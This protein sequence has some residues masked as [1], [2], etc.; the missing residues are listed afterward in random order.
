MLSLVTVPATVALLFLGGVDAFWRMNCGIIHT[1]RVDP[2]V[3]P[4]AVAAHAHTIVGGS[5]IGVNATFNTLLNSECTSCEIAA[6]KSAYWTP[7]LYYQYPN[8]TFLEVP[9]SGSVVYYLARG[10]NADKIIP[11]PK[12]FMILTG[13]KGARSYDNETMTWGN[14]T[15]P[16]R[17]IADRISFVCLPDGPPLPEGRHMFNTTCANGMR[18]QI[19]FQSCWNGKELYKADN[20]HVAYLN[21]IDN[22]I[23]PPDHPIQLPT[24][25]IETLWAVAQVSGQTPQGRFVFSQGDPTGYGFHADFQNGWDSSVLAQAVRDC[26]VPDNFGQISYCPALQASQTNGYPFNCPERPSQI[27]EPVHG[28]LDHLP[29]CV[30]VTEGP[31][32]APASSMNCPASVPKPKIFSTKDSTPR[33]TA[34]PLPG[35]NFG[36]PQQKYLGCYNDSANSIRALNA[37]QT[38]NYTAM[39]VEFCQNYCMQNGYRLSGLEYAQECHCDN[40]LNPT[41][42]SGSNQCT[43]NCG[44][45]MTLGKGTQQF[46]GGLSVISIY[47]N[48]D[49]TFKETG[50]MS[51]TAGNAQPYQDAAPFASNYKGCYS[52]NQPAGRALTG[53]FTQTS[54]NMTL[55][56]CA[57]FCTQGNNGLGFQYYGL[58]FASQCWCGNA[59]ANGNTLLTPTSSP[60]NY[61][62]S[63]RCPR[64][65]AEICGGPS[66][67]SVYNNPRYVP[68]VNK[69]SIGK[70]QSKQCLLDPN[71][72]G[73]TLQ[74]ASMT[75]PK[76][77]EESC[78]KFC[79]GKRFHYAGMEYGTECYCGDTILRNIGGQQVTCDESRI[80]TCGG[81][82]REYC[83]GPGFMSLYY[84]ATL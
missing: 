80:M 11:Y 13:D 28:L 27:D 43:W 54:Y 64:A 68:P 22:G 2:L 25:F 62:C 1:G 45:T 72:G 6:D 66:V 59:I 40:Q 7:I 37:L 71:S 82:N 51:N 17:P 61:T 24:L 74:G 56:Y 49:P 14:A 9:H 8:N 15:Y 81:D 58:E 31:E 4:G 63:Q 34:V 16:G 38:T 18:A 70:Y 36:L 50:D 46:C 33:P 32:V 60:N 41:A 53:A 84:S 65:G 55:E 47:N 19:A 78:V 30:E 79:L 67:L 69:K 35:Q 5:N 39:T 52:D 10:P 83:G 48:T 44:G 73:R 21:D 42:I 57:N 26:L 23:C 12:G 29:G 77:T 75:D 76:L 3:N 20:S